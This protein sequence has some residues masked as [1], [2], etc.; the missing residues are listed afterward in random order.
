MTNHVPPA[1]EPTS[2]ALGTQLTELNNR[3]RWYSTQLWTVPFAYL[4]VSALAITGFLKDTQD[5]LWLVLF[6][7]A[8]VGGFVIWHME[9]IRDGEKRAVENLKNLESQLHLVPT[10]EYKRYIIPF[11]VAVRVFTVLFFLGGVFHLW[12]QFC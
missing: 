3:S 11:L 12:R 5:Q 2:D 1:A 4:G 7:G 6:A 9:G 10:V 8:L